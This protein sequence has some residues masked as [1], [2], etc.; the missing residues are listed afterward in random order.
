MWSVTLN[1]RA[2][3]EWRFLP[4]RLIICELENPDFFLYTDD[5]TDQSQNVWASNLDQDPSSDFFP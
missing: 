2:L 4:R 1:P 3:G 5:V